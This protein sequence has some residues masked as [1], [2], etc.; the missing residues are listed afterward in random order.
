MDQDW[1]KLII[2]AKNQGLT[3]EDVRLFLQQKRR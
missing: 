1:I 2:Q 3:V